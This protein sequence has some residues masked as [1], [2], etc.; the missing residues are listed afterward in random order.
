MLRLILIA[1]L[2]PGLAMAFDYS[3]PGDNGFVTGESV[4]AAHMNELDTALDA[5]EADLANEAGLETQLG[6]VNII[7]Q[8][9]IDT[10]SELNTI[11]TDATLVTGAHTT[12]A[13]DLSSGT[14]PA[15]RVGADHID[16]ITEIAAALKSGSDTTVVTGTA[17]TS[18]TCAEWNADGDLVEA[19]SAA[20]CGAGGGD[21]VQV[22]TLTFGNGSATVVHTY[23]T[24]ST[25]PTLTIDN[26]GKATFSGEVAATSLSAGP[27][28]TPAIDFVDSDTT[29]EDNSVSL[30][31]NCTDT[32]TTTEDCDLSIVQQQAGA[33]VTRISL[34]AD[35]DVDID[36]A[37][38]NI[39]LGDG[40]TTNYLTVSDGGVLSG[41]GTGSIDLGAGTIAG[42]VVINTVSATT[43]SPAVG[44]LDGHWHI[45]TNAAGCDITLPSAVAGMSGCW[46]D[47]NGGGVIT[48]DSAAGDIFYL[49]GTALDAADAIDSA[50]AIGDFACI[51]AIDDTDWLVLGKSGTWVDGGVD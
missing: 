1:L 44:E 50:G 2:V 45:C 43:D 37:G 35:G 33:E 36:A 26:A 27:S 38:G 11:L 22:A 30:D 47:Q 28:A 14:I 23:D 25:D 7:L 17:G 32:A 19:V 20:A 24:N 29:D 41:A 9:E 51:L 12:S 10:L 48:L 5:I 34:D 46:Y 6:G 15:A 4:A 3:S 42:A 16:A 21:D 39:T 18:G 8:T 49:D 40:G 31:V 13:G